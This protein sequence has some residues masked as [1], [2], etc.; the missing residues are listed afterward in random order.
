MSSL[1][2][3]QPDGAASA[4]AVPRLRGRRLWLTIVA[5]ALGLAAVIVLVALNAEDVGDALALANV[6]Q[7]A[8]LVG[9][10][11]VA[12]VLRA[13]TW[14]LCLTAAG[15]PLPRRRLHAASSLR[16]LADTTV[17]TYVGAWVRIAIL[18]RLEGDKA[19]TIGQMITADGLLLLIEACITVV[20]LVGC[21]ALAGLDWY[22]PLLFAMA[23]AA[24]LGGVVILR[25]RFADRA[26][27]RV[28]DVLSDTQ[29][30]V[31]LT[32]LL[33]VVLTIQ[34]VR[35]YISLHAVGLDASA[36]QSLL[37]FVTTS[38]INALPIG[39]GPASVGATVSV[40]GRDGVGAATASGLVLAATAFVAAGFYSVWGALQL[41]R[42][43]DDDGAAAAP[44]PMP[45]P[46]VDVA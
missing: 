35:F 11:L 16:F 45:A 15:K 31:L 37:T 44:E 19:P 24:A 23:A 17:P 34:P 2:S 42:R 33:T 28:F 12:L 21:S 10:H 7:V 22:W 27:V 40:F 8:A 14:G 5:M 26:F 6:G 38:A 9:L 30:R 20:L 13:E 1:P 3:R 46:P 32:V 25:R 36:L 43:R 39:P 29:H 4:E 18:K 41:L